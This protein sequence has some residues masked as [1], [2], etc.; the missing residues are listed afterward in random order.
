MY[1]VKHGKDSY[2]IQHINYLYTQNM[3]KYKM[4]MYNNTY[5]Y[6]IL[7]VLDSNIL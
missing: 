7:F 1:C 2:V 6:I 5:I 3:F 4:F